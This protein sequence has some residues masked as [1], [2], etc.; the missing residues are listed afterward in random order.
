MTE[1]VY[2]ETVSITIR[3]VDDPVGLPY[4]V[5]PLEVVDRTYG[6]RDGLVVHLLGHG[7][8][9]TGMAHTATCAPVRV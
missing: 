3:S 7:A 8:P 5:H 4:T 1:Q 6:D 9:V 2:N